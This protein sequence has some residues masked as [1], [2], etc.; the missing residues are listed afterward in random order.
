MLSR[1]KCFCIYATHFHELTELGTIYPKQLKNV[2]TASQIDRNGRL[3]LL[4]KIIPGIA[5]HSFGLNVGEM[6]G[7][8]ENL[9][10]V[11]YLQF[12]W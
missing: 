1:V 3:I 6:V 9:L 11:R 10:Q 7:L 2:C 8:P 12:F 4:Y 5:G